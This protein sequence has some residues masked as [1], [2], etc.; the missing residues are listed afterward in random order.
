MQYEHSINEQH[1]VIQSAGRSQEQHFGEE[2]L[3]GSKSSS[4][5]SLI[6]PEKKTF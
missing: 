5:L 3:A 2:G 6:I 4:T 1:D